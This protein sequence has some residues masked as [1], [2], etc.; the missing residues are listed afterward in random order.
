M[1]LK[2]RSVFV[3]AAHPDDEVIGCGGTIAKLTQLG[4]K[5]YVTFFSDGESS[6][7]KKKNIK[8]LILQRKK[9][10]IKSSKILGIKEIFFHKFPDNQL[11]KIPILEIIK[12]IENYIKKYKPEMIF[13]HFNDDLNIDHQIISKATITACRP[14][15]KNPVK[16][17]FFFEV[18]SSTEWQIKN[19]KNKIFNPNWFED[20]SKTKEKKIKALKVYKSE[21]RTWPHPRSIKG[22]TSLMQWRGSTSG[23]EA[24]EA[25]M[26]GRSISN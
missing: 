5:V 21:L 16:K 9:A 23:F 17:L 14:Q 8:K 11:D 3:F 2:K 26:L 10:A 25:F 13:T 18:P 19:K 12:L 1:L 6:R 15:N 4:F 22:I 20:I 24:A 7:S